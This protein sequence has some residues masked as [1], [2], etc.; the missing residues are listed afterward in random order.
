MQ[1]REL[2]LRWRGKSGPP[3]RLRQGYGGSRRS[4]PEFTASGGGRVSSRC[5]LGWGSPDARLGS[6]STAGFADRQWRNPRLGR[7]GRLRTRFIHFAL[8]PLKVARDPASLLTVCAEP[9][10]HVAMIKLS[11]SVRS[12][13][14]A[15]RGHVRSAARFGQP[16]AACLAEA[17]PILCVGEAKAG[18]FEKRHAGVPIG[19]GGLSPLS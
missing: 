14:A 16:A 11:A 3:S 13:V 4:S 9:R 6:A 12:A 10:K 5:V 19:G 2:P 7:S 8:T 18:Q 1:G 15:A 17:S